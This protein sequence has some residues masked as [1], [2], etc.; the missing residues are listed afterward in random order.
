MRYWTT[1]VA[2]QLTIMAYAWVSGR[3]LG[4]LR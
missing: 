3:L 2:W 1:Y 4:V